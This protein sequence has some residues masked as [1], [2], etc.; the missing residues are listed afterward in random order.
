MKA[1]GKVA[2]LLLFSFF[3][4]PGSVLA[5]VNI[6][7]ASLAE[8]DTL[9]GIGPATAQKIIDARPYATKEEISRAD[10]IGEP[11]S[12]SYDN[13]IG[14]IT[15]SGSQDSAEE[16]EEE[17]TEEEQPEDDGDGSSRPKTHAA[18]VVLVA[19][20][21]V[22]AGAPARFAA[23]AY[24]ENGKPLSYGVRYSWNFGDGTVGAEQEP[25]H[26]YSFAG[27][28]H[29]RVAVRYR[30]EELVAREQV[31][32]VAPTITV[33]AQ[34]DGSVVLTNKTGAELDLG[35]WSI[36]DGGNQFY[37]PA[38]TY[39]GAGQQLRLPAKTLG[40]AASKVAALRMPGGAVVPAAAPVVAATPR[41]AAR[42]AVPIVQAAAPAVGAEEQLAAAV[43]AP[44]P[45]GLAPLLPYAGLVAVL[46]VGVAG[47]Y[48]A[49]VPQGV[50]KPTPEEFDIE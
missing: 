9:P 20:A 36:V 46:A 12:P 21:A 34:S 35:Y 44:V 16:E 33:V 1:T 2:A 8:L 49:R 5:L 14:L 30:G 10:G 38:N 29:V 6:N 25:L 47:A 13:I 27:P 4:A 18:E 31:A 40:F 41:S 17:D 3:V 28:Y 26:T 15:V 48:Y 19:P 43:A 42:A 45:K 39:V 37:V 24:D 22:V 11:G 23:Q 7:T 50:T 32:A